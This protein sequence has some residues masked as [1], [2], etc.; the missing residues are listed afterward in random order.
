MNRQT[1]NRFDKFGSVPSRKGFTSSF[2][3]SK[4]TSNAIFKD[5]WKKPPYIIGLARLLM[6]NNKYQ[7][8]E[9]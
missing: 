7:Y 9:S 5:T 6:E 3:D 1:S 4:I 8:H 2:M